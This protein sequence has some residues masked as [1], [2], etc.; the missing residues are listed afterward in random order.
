MRASDIVRQLHKFLPSFADD[1]TDNYEAVSASRVGTT[2]TIDLGQQPNLRENSQVFI[3]G[4]LHSMAL[5]SFSISGRYAEI[6]SNEDHDFTENDNQRANFEL[7]DGSTFS[8]PIAR[9]RNRRQFAVDLGSSVDTAFFLPELLLNGFNPCVGFNGLQMVT[10]LTSTGFTFE[11]DDPVSD[12]AIGTISVRTSPRI[13]AALDI[14]SIAK[15]YTKQ[16]PADD[17]TFNNRERAWLFVVLGDG[18]SSK[19]RRIDTDAVDNSQQGQ[20]LNTKLLQSVQ[21]F[22]VI[23]T[24]RTLSGRAARD[25]CEELLRPICRSLLRFK[26]PSL[27]T[28][29]TNPLQITS[30]GLQS[31]NNAYYIHQYSFESTLQLGDEDVFVEQDD[32]AFRD[33]SMAIESDIGDTEFDIDLDDEPIV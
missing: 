13:T 29:T 3:S 16:E 9:V 21:L 5:D 14:E 23:P 6:T 15:G 30:H 20:Y 28:N 17:Q 31:Y 27:V 26:P 11:N 22:V 18:V 7:Q 24:S 10:S 1:F 8:A 19:N 4:A 12:D 32:V 25:R 33:I 2:V